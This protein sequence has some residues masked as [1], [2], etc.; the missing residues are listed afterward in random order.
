MQRSFSSQNVVHFHLYNTALYHKVSYVR[1]LNKVINA[2]E[3]VM[4]DRLYKN[5][6]KYLLK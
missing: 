3:I 6:F 4:T 5:C 1:I 2:F